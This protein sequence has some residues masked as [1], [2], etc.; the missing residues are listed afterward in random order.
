M[1]DGTVRELT[2]K[3]Q[4]RLLINRLH[5]EYDYS[6]LG[7]RS[8]RKLTLPELWDLIKGSQIVAELNPQQQMG[9]PGKDYPRESDLRAM[10]EYDGTTAL[11]A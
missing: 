9:E 10:K 7:D 4:W 5:T 3:E 1:G 11:G 6:Y 2:P 8:Y